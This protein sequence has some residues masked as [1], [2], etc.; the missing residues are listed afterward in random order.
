MD[1]MN[2]FPDFFSEDDP[3]D[4]EEDPFE[5]GS[6]LPVPP[7]DRLW[8]HPSELSQWGPS[9][10]LPEL[11][12][13]S[14]SLLNKGKAAT[15]H[16]HQWSTAILGS[17][18]GAAV[19]TALLLA[20]ST[21]NA[22]P[23]GI[24]LHNR[25]QTSTASDIM[26][27][28][29]PYSKQTNTRGR[30]SEEVPSSGQGLGSGQSANGGN[31]GPL[32]KAGSGVVKLAAS[33]R[34]SMVSLVVTKRNCNKSHKNC[35]VRGSG[36]VFAQE[37]LVMTTRALT[38]N[39]S[40]IAA[41][42]PNNSYVP[43][44]VVASDPSSGISVLR[45]PDLAVPNATF[46]LTR[47]PRLGQFIEEVAA[48]PGK[49]SPASVAIGT[50]TAAS[51]RVG[52]VDNSPLIDVFETDTP[53]PLNAQGSVLLNSDGKVMGVVDYVVHH[54]SFATSICT[55]AILALGVARQLVASGHVSHGWLGIE[56][57]NV[58]LAGSSQPNGVRV[59]SVVA[60]SA[61]ATAGLMPGDIIRG[62]DGHQVNSMVG[63]QEEL[64]ILKPNTPVVL[65]V[66]RGGQWL[67]LTTALSAQ[68]G[69]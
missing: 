43:A 16:R 56:G 51:Q 15:H 64:Y 32:V 58:D 60:G 7:D 68:P 49:G 45:I 62:L 21:F 28:R 19:A 61:A 26:F 53:P 34:P 18:A 44:T 29:L 57:S 50:V 31:S 42:T 47:G 33:I 36:V 55:P 48:L 39:A 20:S 5:L 4:E 9:R 35:T 46:D 14:G 54:G 52:D 17:A 6:S 25:V 40:K 22:L 23:L 2:E 8:R 41:F 65:W 24:R 59:D 30:G 3:Y 67:T 12:G 27:T 66:E 69:K 63:L 11:A 10:E 13:S 37:D 38:R 1:G